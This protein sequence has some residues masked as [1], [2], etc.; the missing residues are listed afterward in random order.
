MRGRKDSTYDDGLLAALRTTGAAAATTPGGTTA[1]TGGT[2]AT[3][4][5]GTTT[6]TAGSTA[7]SSKSLVNV[8]ALLEEDEEI[9]KR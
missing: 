1:P 6:A 5:G 7:C 8:R 2:T 4:T 9:D 3:T